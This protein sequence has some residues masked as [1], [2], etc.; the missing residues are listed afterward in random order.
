MADHGQVLPARRMR[1]SI[2]ARQFAEGA[3]LEDEWKKRFDAYR[4]EFP[5]EAAEFELIM[6][7]KLPEN[8]TADLPKWKP[9]DKPVATRAAGGE[10]INALAKH[11]PNLVGGSADLNP[12]TRTAL[13]GLG[14][15]Q[16]PELSGPGTLGAVGGEWRLWRPE[17]R[18]RRSGTRHGRGGE[19]NGG[20]WRRAALQR[21][22]L[23][24]FRL[25]ETGHP[26]GGVKPVSGRFTYLRT[27]AS[28]WARMVPRI[29]Q[30]SSWPACARS[31]ILP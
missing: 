25:H 27:T 10:V 4:Q 1:W 19:W 26:A 13:K 30:S 2:S 16:A 28:A 20:T 15:F 24:V 17:Y 8:W 11:I 7:G 31:Q 29:N 22:I 3:K 23:D 5:K 18:F 14:D 12:S 6:S 21:D 9:T